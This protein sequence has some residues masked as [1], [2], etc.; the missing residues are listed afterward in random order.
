MTPDALQLRDIHLPEAIGWWPPAPGWWLLLALTLLLVSL[1][2][3]QLKRY[4]RRHYHR[5]GLQQLLELEQNAAQRDSRL[6]LQQLSQ[7]MRHMA[8]LHFPDADCAA[9]HGEEWLQF[10]NRPFN[11][12][13]FTDGVGR[14][15]ASGPYQPHTDLDEESLSALI[16]LCRRW[17][18]QLPLAPKVTANGRR[19]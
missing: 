8:I 15:L 5:L 2:V 17:L 10:L 4:H 11:D 19:K 13:P 9:L 6:L 1:I 12:Q 7:L 18:K 14:P 16:R 3:W